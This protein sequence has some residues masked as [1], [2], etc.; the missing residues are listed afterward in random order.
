MNGHR[1]CGHQ[2]VEFSKSVSDGSAIE[3]R[4]D[5]TRV[6]VNIVDV[7]DITVVDLLVVIVLDLHHLVAAAESPAEP[8]DLP[9][10]G[11]IERCL[12]LDVQLARAHATSV[13]WAPH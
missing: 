12:Q 3:T 1:V 4:N 9:I 6:G 7:A 5:L 13:A 8:L 11:G 2:H 10:T